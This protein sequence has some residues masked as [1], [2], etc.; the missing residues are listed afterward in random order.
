[1]IDI[2][3][4]A[5]TSLIA[6]YI[7]QFGA[8]AINFGIKIALARLLLPT[9]WGVYAEAMLVILVADTFTDIGLSQ[10]LMREK[11]RPYGNVLLIRFILSVIAF[12]LIQ[13]FAG[14]FAFL[15]PEVVEPLR[16]LSPLIM[17]RAVASIPRIYMDRELIVYRSLI[18]Q[19]VSL[20]AMGI[21]S[22]VLAAK[23][24]GVYALIFGS[25]VQELVWC[26]LLWVSVVRILPVQLTLQHTWRLIY[27][28]RYLFMIAVIGFVLQQGDIAITG[29]LLSSDQVGLYAMAYTIIALTSK[30]VETAIYRVVYPLFCQYADDL[31]TL[32][33]IY[34]TTTLAMV[35]IEAPI[36][37]F[38][39]FNSGFFVSNLLGD[40]WMPMAHLL[41][42]LAVAGIINPYTTFGIEVLRATKR[43]KMLTVASLTG[44]V[45]LVFF[46]AILTSRYGAIG[47]VVAN[48]FIFG[49]VVTIIALLRVIPQHIKEL[50]RKLAAVYSVSLLAA[51]LPYF[52]LADKG[53]LQNVVS[54]GAVLLSWLVFYRYYGV[55]L[56]RETLGSLERPA[57]PGVA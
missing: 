12:L 38:L 35:A 32:G 7:S 57:E 9:E 14:I 5:I 20:I 33:R 37:F 8:S 17:L 44:A 54:I 10:H 25:L 29:T 28:S 36:Y 31:R 27:G 45:S 26:V 11:N 47:M 39:L 53:V 21:V 16:V 55:P 24:F 22:L 41:A 23:G 46:G 15:S 4:R 52:T 13:A 56:I 6:S 49:S 42:G 40:K 34:V 19:F 18:P 3:R 43:D 51:A 30:M 2:K 1:M 50:T 48:Y